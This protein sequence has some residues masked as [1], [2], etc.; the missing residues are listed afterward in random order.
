MGQRHR[1][2]G[3]TRFFINRT[4]AHAVPPKAVWG[5][6]GTA[7]SHALGCQFQEAAIPPVRHRVPSSWSFTLMHSEGIW[8]WYGGPQITVL[9]CEVFY[10][11]SSPDMP[12]PHPTGSYGC[13]YL[14]AAWSW[15]Q[16]RVL[17]YDP[18]GAPVVSDGSLRPE[19]AAVASAI[20]NKS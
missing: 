14:Q 19:V 9:S 8:N 2:V 7:V 10:F 17:V 15:N 20:V 5:G 13:P 6:P 18:L 16:P 1:P 12:R 3:H 4:L 11:L